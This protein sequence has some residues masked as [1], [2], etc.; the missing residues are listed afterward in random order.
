MRREEESREM[1]APLGPRLGRIAAGQKARVVV[2]LAVELALV[3][4]AV[5]GG[6]EQRATVQATEAVLVE[7]L[8]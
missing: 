1:A 8:G 7:S 6:L 4:T 3:Q 2:R 5:L